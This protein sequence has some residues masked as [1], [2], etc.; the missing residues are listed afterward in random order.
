MI[1][2]PVL[3]LKSGEKPKLN[4]TEIS[5]TSVQQFKEVIANCY[6]LLFIH[7]FYNGSSNNF[8]YFCGI[9]EQYGLNGEDSN[10]IKSLRNNNNDDSITFSYNFKSDGIFEIII[11]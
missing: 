9:I 8:Q 4:S 5:I 10:V 7:Q 11:S 6:P 3:Y 1:T 2:R